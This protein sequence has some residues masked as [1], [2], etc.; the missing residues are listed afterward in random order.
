MS[1]QAHSAENDAPRRVTGLVDRLL[2]EW[3]AGS[4]VL[5]EQSRDD[6]L[7]IRCCVCGSRHGLVCVARGWGGVYACRVCD[8]ETRPS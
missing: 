2:V 6:A 4:Q 7:N 3:M 5:A 1:D 8:A